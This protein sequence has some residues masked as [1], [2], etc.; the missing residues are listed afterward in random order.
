[1]TSTTMTATLTTGRR[2]TPAPRRRIG[3]KVGRVFGDVG[4]LLTV[5]LIIIPLVLTV[6]ASFRTP[7]AVAANP[8]GFPWQPT[9]DNYQVALDRM[10]YLPSVVNTFIILIVSLVIIIGFGSLAAYPLARLTRRWTAGMYRL[11]ILGMTLPIF[12]II[13]PLFI[14]LRDLGMLD[15]RFGVILIYAGMFLPVAIFFYT[16]FLRQVPEELEEAAALDGAGSLRT[17]RVVIFPL[18][19]PITATLGIYLSLHIWNDLVVPLVFI[20]DP[21]K[22]TVMVNAYAYINPYTV[23]P[24]ELFPA[25]IL[26][27]LPL[28]LIFAF[29]Q[30]K[31]VQGLTLGAG[32]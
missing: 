8:L 11:F 32:K 1:M 6:F 19:R 25:A 5:I 30:G 3:A 26:G 17:F 24:T 18:L 4:L 23:D 7:E 2:S 14:L 27:V 29:M 15:T 16:S 9:L 22:R 20:S 28:V 13:G 31:V 10:N 12:V 21:G